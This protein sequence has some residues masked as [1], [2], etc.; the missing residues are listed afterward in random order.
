MQGVERAIERQQTLLRR[1]R[2]DGGRDEQCIDVR[3]GAGEPGQGLAFALRARTRIDNDCR[4]TRR[5]LESD[6][7]KV[8]AFIDGER[9][10]FGYGAVDQNPM[11]SVSHLGF[12]QPGIG[13]VVDRAASK[14]GHQLRD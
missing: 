11:R 6:F 9:I 7:H 2:A 1:P 12:D 4:A 3:I 14:R 10:G 8:V 5:R 13:I